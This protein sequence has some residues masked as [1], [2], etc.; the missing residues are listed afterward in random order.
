[1]RET[2]GPDAGEGA[3]GRTDQQRRDRRREAGSIVP[4]PV[5]NGVARVRKLFHDLRS[6]LLSYD[7]YRSLD[8]ALPDE[9]RDRFV[10]GD[11][12][13]FVLQEDAVELVVYDRAANEF[14]GYRVRRDRGTGPI[15][16]GT[17]EGRTIAE[18]A[19]RSLLEGAD[20]VDTVPVRLF[21][22]DGDGSRGREGADG[23]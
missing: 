17:D 23:G 2:D 16:V 5:R 3:S 20:L 11:H 22:P 9:R 19:L 12:Y 18:E 21:D 6:V 8:A 4:T 15:A 13:L 10:D 7:V 14:T 1:M